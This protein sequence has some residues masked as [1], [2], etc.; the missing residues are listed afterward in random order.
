MAESLRLLD[1]APDNLPDIKQAEK[2]TPSGG[3]AGET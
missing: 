3:K 2:I 1:I